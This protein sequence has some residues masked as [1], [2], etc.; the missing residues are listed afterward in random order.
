MFGFLHQIR[1]IYHLELF[2]NYFLKYKHL[3]GKDQVLLFPQELMFLMLIHEQTSFLMLCF[4]LCLLF[5]C[6][7][8]SLV[9]NTMLIALCAMLTVFF[10]CYLNKYA[11]VLLSF[12]C[13]PICK[14]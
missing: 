9:F 11:V 1:K 4:H 12:Y 6:V 13:S 7:Y 2:H 5:T 10:Y 14:E 3:S 8:Y